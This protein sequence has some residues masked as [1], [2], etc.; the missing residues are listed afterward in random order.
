MTSSTLVAPPTPELAAPVAW[1]PC[2]DGRPADLGAGLCHRCGW[3]L[4]DHTPRGGG[5]AARAA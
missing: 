5:V 1:E 3:P 2:T 4:D